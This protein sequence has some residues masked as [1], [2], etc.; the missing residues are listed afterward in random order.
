MTEIISLL[1]ASKENLSFSL[2]LALG[3][4]SVFLYFISSKVREI[5]ARET[6]RAHQLKLVENEKQLAQA[7]LRLLQAQ[8]EPHFLFNTMSNIGA[9][10]E[11]APQSSRKLLEDL[12]HYLR[13][14]LRHSRNSHT[15]LG[16]EIKLLEYFLAIHQ[17]RMEGRVHYWIDVPQNLLSCAFPPMLLQPLVENAIKH[18]IEPSVHGGEILIE[19]EAGEGRLRITVSDTGLGLRADAGSG[20]GIANIRERLNTL[21]DGAGMVEVRGNIPHGVIS[22][23]EVPDEQ[24]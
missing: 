4:G 24:G 13:A 21:Y 1:P 20:F 5:A 16:E 19:A 18:G 8:I 2:V 23:L 6:I 22:I 10:I 17:A 11:V 15:T 3:F 7:Q 14:A 12:T 9:M